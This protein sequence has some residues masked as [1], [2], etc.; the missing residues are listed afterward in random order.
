VSPSKSR[1][2]SVV[3]PTCNRPELLRE[4]LASIRA[5][6]G[7]DL[8][9]EILVGD[10]GSMPATE[11]AA[12][13]YG[14]RHLRTKTPGA[15]AARN[16]AMRAATGDYLAF[17]DDDDLWLGGHLRTH[18]ERLEADASLLGVVGQVINS[19]V[20]RR[21]ISEP[22][23]HAPPRDGRMFLAMLAGYFPQI[24]ATLTRVRARDAVGEFDEELIGDQDWDWH[25]RLARQGLVGFVEVPSVLF[26]QRPPASFDALQLK[27]MPY[28]R[29]VFA[30]HARFAWPMLRSP[31]ALFRAYD[32][33]LSVFYS[34][35]I[36]AALIRAER[37]ERL[38]ALRSIGNAFRAVPVRASWHLLRPTLLRRAL[39]TAI[40]TNPR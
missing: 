33:A 38:E 27:R 29:K 3:V 32:G 23:P 2:V 25:L 6:E 35:F 10:N 34:Y 1:R 16:V 7:P 20:E 37:G 13:E 12:K 11:A 9:L 31:W 28:T 15:A 4:A 17:L 22:W 39:I 5:L 36:E 30:R 18:L 14:A 24:G 26:R 19:D 8:A 40:T 21:P